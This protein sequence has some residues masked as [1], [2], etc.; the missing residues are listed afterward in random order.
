MY[1]YEQTCIRRTSRH[2]RLADEWPSGE[3]EVR[4]LGQHAPALCHGQKVRL[5]LVFAV[6]IANLAASV[7]SDVVCSW[8]M[9][10]VGAFGAGISAKSDVGGR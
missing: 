2:F 8:K 1:G 7:K 9:A 5:E 10:S 3:P 4:S 6:V